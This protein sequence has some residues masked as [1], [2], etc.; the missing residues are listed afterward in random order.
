MGLS[1]FL[2]HGLPPTNSTQDTISSFII[3]YGSVIDWRL[4][5]IKDIKA[6]YKTSKLSFKTMTEETQSRYIDAKMME[7]TMMR[8]IYH[9]L[10][11]ADEADVA[12]SFA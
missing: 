8:M 4:K 9:G 5:S 3:F 1:K 6:L 10:Q 11:P 12:C 2:L 7:M